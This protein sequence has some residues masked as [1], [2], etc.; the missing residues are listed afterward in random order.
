MTK[1]QQEA[2]LKLLYKKDEK[3]DLKNWRPISLL[4]ADYKIITKTL[5]NRLKIALNDII[6]QDQTCGIPGRSIFSTL[7]LYRNI[8]S[9]ANQK[10][11]QGYIIALDQEKAFDRVNHQ[12][13]FKIM[14][15]YD[16]GPNFLNW[17]RAIYTENKSYLLLNGYLSLPVLIKRGVRQGCPL[18]ALLYLMIAEVL[19]EAIRQDQEV[20]GYPLPGTDFSVKIAQYAD[21]TGLFLLDKESV[22]RAFWIVSRFEDGSGSKLNL[23]KCEG[24]PLHTLR[25]GERKH[26]SKIAHIK[27]LDNNTSIKLLGIRFCREYN[28]SCILNF[29]ILANKIHDK[30]LS[31]SKRSLSIKGRVQVANTLLTSK[32][33]YVA[34]I[35][36]IPINIIAKINKTIFTYIW[37]NKTELI[38]RDSI[39]LPTKTG[40]LGLLDVE[41][42][43][44][45]LK[46][47]QWIVTTLLVMP[48]QVFRP[49]LD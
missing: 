49:I 46:I 43:A 12:F 22:I 17:I 48:L 44:H 23:S 40:G 35:L 7:S 1:T 5:A 47:K 33:W 30:A 29:Q 8:I 37:E 28:L 11:I 10:H 21:D 9:H 32:L 42:Q 6:S 25:P 39:S 3:D 45:A 31:L 26:L 14:E 27:W 19:A 2:V 36:D 13:L 15:K 20:R 34:T 4:C 18:S 41:T 16:F 24:F 38:R